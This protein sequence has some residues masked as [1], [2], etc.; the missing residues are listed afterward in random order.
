MEEKNDCASVSEGSVTYFHGDKISPSGAKML[1]EE[2]R[3]KKK[4]AV[5][6]SGIV[7]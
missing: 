3:I 2:F 7:V 6:E 1:E 4:P 5:L